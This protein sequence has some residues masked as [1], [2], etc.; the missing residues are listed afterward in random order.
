MFVFLFAIVFFSDDF[1]FA[2]VR[3]GRP[4]LRWWTLLARQQLMGLENEE[5]RNGL[6]PGIII[7][8]VTV[9][10]SRLCKLP[11]PPQNLV[12]TPPP[13]MQFAAKDLRGGCQVLRCKSDAAAQGGEGVR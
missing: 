6:S 12:L 1:V 11:P 9:S 8:I 7:R 4:G 3:P 13:I 2:C 5:F 10:R